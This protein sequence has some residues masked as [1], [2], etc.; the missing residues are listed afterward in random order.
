MAVESPGFILS[1]R[2]VQQESCSETL[3]SEQRPLKK[4]KSADFVKN[5]KLFQNQLGFCRFFQ[6][7]GTSNRRFAATGF[8]NKLIYASWLLG[9]PVSQT[10]PGKK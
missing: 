1:I 9:R 7:L 5:L 8:W 3:V 10:E 4:T 6:G 2:I